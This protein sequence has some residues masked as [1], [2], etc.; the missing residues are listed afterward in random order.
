MRKTG[1]VTCWMVLTVVLLLSG[2]AGI[3]HNLPLQA[4][5]NEVTITI[6]VMSGY[7]GGMSVSFNPGLVSIPVGGR[8]TWKNDSNS[9]IALSSSQAGMSTTLPSGGSFPFVFNTA[10][11]YSVTA[12]AGSASATMTVNV[13]TSGVPAEQVQEFAL[14]HSLK[15]FKIYPATLT[16]KKGIKVRLFNTATDGSHPII[17]ISSD[18]AGQNAVFGVKPFDVEV[19]RLTVVEFTPDQAGTFFITHRPHGHNIVGQLIVTDE[20][21]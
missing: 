7:Y 3:Y 15:D 8:V 16:V 9:L 10:G 12:Q 11:S 6:Q 21:K 2:I 14:I 20:T 17:A 1:N 19:G 13:T 18:Q 5:S 4:Q